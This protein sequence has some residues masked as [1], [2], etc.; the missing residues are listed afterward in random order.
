MLY[1]VK[2]TYPFYPGRIG[3]AEKTFTPAN[4]MFYPIDGKHPWRVVI[5][6]EELEEYDSNSDD[7]RTEPRQCE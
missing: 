6:W 5:P 7:I 3:K 4:A 1:R 2:S